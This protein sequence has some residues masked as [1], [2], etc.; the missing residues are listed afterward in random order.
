[1]HRS[2]IKRSHILKKTLP[3]FERI[4]I[5]HDCLNYHKTFNNLMIDW[6]TVFKNVDE[7]TPAH[8]AAQELCKSVLNHTTVL[9]FLLCKRYWIKPSHEYIRKYA[10]SK[11]YKFDD[12]FQSKYFPA[13]QKLSY[14]INM[15]VDHVRTGLK[16]IVK[17]YNK[18]DDLFTKLVI[19]SQK[20]HLERVVSHYLQ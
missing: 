1:M 8:E 13:E 7:N 3:D 18:S 4:M 11:Q 19:K 9:V 10:P 20:H 17:Q 15:S 14:N 2:L 5:S 12:V 16:N 6:Y